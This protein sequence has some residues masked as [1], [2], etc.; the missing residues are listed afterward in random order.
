MA[1]LPGLRWTAAE[2]LAFE[3]EAEIRHEFID[4]L[5]YAM[6]GAPERHNQLTSALNFL[7]YGQLLE[8]DCQVFLSDMRVRID[9]KVFFYPDVVVVCGEA[10]YTD[11]RRDMLLN[12]TAVFEV[13]SPST[14]D[15]DRGTKFSFYRAIPTLR[16]YVLV[17]Q[18][19]IQ[20]E[21]YTRQSDN[22]WVLRDLTQPDDQI[23]LPS[24]GCM[25]AL[26]DVYR[27]VRFEESD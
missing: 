1:A 18:K 22:R 11:S 2:Y 6:A 7:L 15:F 9:E 14:Q 12:P 24:I 8:R 5:V 13:L 26:N 16:D 25:L 4:G 27:R 20:V 21:H 10:R 3:R 17:S 23:T 19:Q